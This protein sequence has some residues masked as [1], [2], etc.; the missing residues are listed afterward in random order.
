M[1]T[2]VTPWRSVA[3][4]R[5]WSNEPLARHTSLRIGGPVDWFVEPEDLDELRAV[6]QEAAQQ[7]EPVWL[8]GG[9]TN[10]LAP[11]RGVRGVAM[12]LR[13][14]YF[15]ELTVDEASS[16]TQAVRVWC[17]AG[18]T[19]HRVVL[20][21]AQ[22]G[23]GGAERLAGLPG[24]IGGAVAMNAQDIGQFVE[25][26]VLVDYGGQVR[27]LTRAALRFCY[28]YTDM[29]EGVM[30]RVRLAFPRVPQ[31]EA[32]AAIDHV[33]ARRKTTQELSWSSAG[34]AF[35]NPGGDCQPAGA[36]IDR[37]GLK[38]TRVGEAQ[39]SLRH[40]NFII[41]LGHATA[42]DVLGLMERIQAQVRRDHGV[43]LEPEVRILGERLA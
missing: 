38:G 19:T 15:T 16:T 42:L 12:H 30:V 33:F 26:V 1:G 22:A 5:I 35:K 34:C 13:R 9:G 14:P 11:D 25:E 6:L 20:A 40:A 41:N 8:I 24:S 37:S 36:L 4:G 39:V 18:L 31:A 43:W 32:A 17:G 10:L 27:H 23:W 28:R 2:S 21:A 7:Q 29:P 3:R